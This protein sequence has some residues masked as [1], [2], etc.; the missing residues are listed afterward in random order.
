MLNAVDNG[1]IDEKPYLDKLPF[2]IRN[3]D[4]ITKLTEQIKE[5]VIDTKELETEINNN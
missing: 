1:E 4:K 3:I 5:M 2:K